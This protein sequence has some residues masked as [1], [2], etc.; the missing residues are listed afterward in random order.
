MLHNGCVCHGECTKDEAP[1]N[2]SNR[3]ERYPNLAQAGIEEAVEYG[4]EKDD[5]KRVNIL[6]NVIGDAMELHRT[7]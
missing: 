6:H 2:T 4:N 5:S 1:C 7:G 3:S